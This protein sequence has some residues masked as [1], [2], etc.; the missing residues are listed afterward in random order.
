MALPEFDDGSYEFEM[1]SLL[2]V[3]GVLRYIV[4]VSCTPINT[5]RRDLTLSDSNIFWK[6][7]RLSCIAACGLSHYITRSV[8]T[9]TVGRRRTKIKSEISEVLLFWA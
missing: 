2:S 3:E 7:I 4:L 9:V 6:R 5:E 1:G 8:I